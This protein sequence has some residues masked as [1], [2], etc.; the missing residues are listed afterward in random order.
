VSHT[1]FQARTSERLSEGLAELQV[2]AT[3]AQFEALLRYLALLE[4]WNAV[5]NLTAVRDQEA[6]V[7]HHILDCLAVLPPLRRELTAHARPRLVDVGSGA[8][9]PGIL[10][11]I[12][13]PELDVLCVDSV[14]KKVAFMDQVIAETGLRNVR[15]RHAR[16][17]S[18]RDSAS[19]VTARAY[20]SLRKLITTTAHLLDEHG[21]WMAMKG[22][23]PADELEAVGAAVDVFHVE[24]LRVP[25]LPDSRCLV[26][27][28]PRTAA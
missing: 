28:R 17:E 14:A 10:L 21:A 16:V 22:K 6:M 18:V 1:G 5:Y 9:L 27:M 20:A 23:P 3:P 13:D 26:W 7:S 15:T 4:R 11:G 8:G 12:M 25:G 19:V 2:P 24:P